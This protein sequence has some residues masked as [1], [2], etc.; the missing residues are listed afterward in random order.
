MANIS[1]L[2]SGSYRARVHL[3]GGKYKFITGKDKK[4]SPAHERQS[5]NIDRWQKYFIKIKYGI[6]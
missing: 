5:L 6:E 3:G 1:R 4:R 2:P